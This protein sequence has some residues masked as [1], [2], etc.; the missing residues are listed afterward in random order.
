MATRPTAST[1]DKRSCFE[2]RMRVGFLV[3]IT[4]SFST[5]ERRRATCFARQSR[6]PS[7]V[8]RRYPSPS[9]LFS[10]FSSI[11]SQ[12]LELQHLESS[13]LE[14]D[15]NKHNAAHHCHRDHPSEHPHGHHARGLN[16]DALVDVQ[17]PS[18]TT[19]IANLTTTGVAIT[20]TT[21]AST[22][23]VTAAPTV[24]STTLGRILSDIQTLDIRSLQ[25]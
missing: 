2:S 16:A 17:P 12:I 23:T 5:A 1:P 22:T 3:R 25:L 21:F 4:M 6:Q 18:T 24:S 15:N 19:P 14:H 20:S 8:T 13:A 10:R 7:P 9:S 11:R